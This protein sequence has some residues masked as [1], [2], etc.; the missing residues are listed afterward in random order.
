[1]GTHGCKAMPAVNRI[2]NLFERP[3]HAA[4]RAPLSHGVTDGL[5]DAEVLAVLDAVSPRSRT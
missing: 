5:P 1:M 2:P 4:T 3:S